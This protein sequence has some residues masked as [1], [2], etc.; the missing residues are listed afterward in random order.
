MTP[1]VTFVLPV[2]NGEQY[3][4]ASVTSMLDQ[5]YRDLELIVVDDGGTDASR[6]IIET[7]D[8]ARVR[9]VDGPGKGLASALNT[10][11]KAASGEFVARLDVDDIAAPDRI[12][13]QV[14]YLDRHPEAVV[15]G[16][17]VD[18]MADDGA[19]LGVLRVAC[20]QADVAAALAAGR[21]PFLH[22]TIMFR[23][24]QAVEA[25]LYDARLDGVGGEDAEFWQRLC[26]KGRGAN[27][28]VP[29]VRYRL[30]RGAIS[31]GFPLL[32]SR[33]QMR[34]QEALRRLCLGTGTAAD[35]ESIRTVAAAARAIDPELA[36]NYRVGKV[37]L[38]AGGDPRV[39]VRYLARAW[40]M[41]PVSLR[42]A[43]NLGVA[44]VRSVVDHRHVDSQDS[45]S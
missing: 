14:E 1:R 3:V 8:D 17:W 25:G 39:A 11:L 18:L 6:G 7:F 41:R 27:L 30:S 33:E 32:S 36:Y 24:Q 45:G 13:Q 23:R 31:D 4:G 10:G 35:L 28:G 38:Q 37:V 5:T 42:I 16:S 22:P 43:K 19:P 9:I 29:L 15:V 44:V 40:R 2:W 21:N 26:K 20:R 34:R 12:R